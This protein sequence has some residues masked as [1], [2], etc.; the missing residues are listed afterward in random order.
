MTRCTQ[1]DYTMV[2]HHNRSGGSRAK[3]RTFTGADIGSGHDL[4]MVTFRVRLKG[5]RKLRTPYSSSTWTNLKMP[6]FSACLR[7]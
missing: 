5:Q 2:Q 3:T 4:V 6:T 7:R 1:I